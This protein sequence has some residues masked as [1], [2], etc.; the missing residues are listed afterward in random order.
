LV[1]SDAPSDTLIGDALPLGRVAARARAT[2]G[3]V[4]TERVADARTGLGALIH[5]ASESHAAVVAPTGA[6]KGRSVLIPWLLSY[7][8]SVIAVD[9]KGEAAY[10]TSRH[11]RQMGQRVAIFDP[12]GRCRSHKPGECATAHAFN[13]MSVLLE[14]STDL[15]DDCMALAELLVGE[16]PVSMQDPFWRALALDLLVAL[17]GWLWVRARVTGKSSPDDG[18]ALSRSL[19]SR[20]R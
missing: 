3:F 15:G 9:P 1:S 19:L 11:R 18:T 4:N 12:W 7:C 10:V 2:P 17:I 20:D 5:D 6:G 8:G 16:A 13:P 14:H